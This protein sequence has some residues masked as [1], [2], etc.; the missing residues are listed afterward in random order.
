MMVEGWLINQGES[1][2]LVGRLVGAGLTADS[3]SLMM[4]TIGVFMVGCEHLMVNQ[5]GFM[6]GQLMVD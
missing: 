3:R 1:R 2:R 5:W 6:V 4:K